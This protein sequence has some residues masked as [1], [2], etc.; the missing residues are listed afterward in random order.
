M[1]VC[2]GNGHSLFGTHTPINRSCEQGRSAP[3]RSTHTPR[4]GGGAAGTAPPPKSPPTH[5]GRRRHVRCHTSD[6]RRT[7]S[8]CHHE[9]VW[10][11]PRSGPCLARKH[12]RVRAV[13]RAATRPDAGGHG[14]CGRAGQGGGLCPPPTAPRPQCLR[15]RRITPPCIS[16]LPPPPPRLITCARQL[17]HLG[18]TGIPA[19]AS[20]THTRYTHIYIQRSLSH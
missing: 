10:R 16:G 1:C 13:C 18:Q 14:R 15:A 11:S 5:G 12:V 4:G 7:L 3:A 8:N 19:H 20:H 17:Q 9:N 6:A 2:A